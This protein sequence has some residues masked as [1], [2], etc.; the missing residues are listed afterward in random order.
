MSVKVCPGLSQP[1]TLNACVTVTPPARSW[2]PA[3]TWSVR[4]SAMKA[5]LRV[6]DSCTSTGANFSPVPRVLPGVSAANSRRCGGYVRGRLYSAPAPPF[7]PNDANQNPPNRTVSVPRF[8]I[9]NRRANRRCSG[10]R[11]RCCTTA[12]SPTR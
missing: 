9:S 1:N 5:T 4:L 11:V 7:N 6:G 8:V 12:T 2:T 3:E 10:S